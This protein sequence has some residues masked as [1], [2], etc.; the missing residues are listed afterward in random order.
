ML[1]NAKI[2]VF[3]QYS[4]RGEIVKHMPDLRK[5]YTFW[6]CGRMA[7]GILSAEKLFMV[8]MLITVFTCQQIERDSLVLFERFQREDFYA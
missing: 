2:S 1:K 3:G 8:K 6:F 5:N 4:I 7:A